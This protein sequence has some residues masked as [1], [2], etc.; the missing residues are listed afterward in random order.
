MYEF[1]LQKKKRRETEKKM[2]ILTCV[3]VRTLD[4]H[5]SIPPISRVKL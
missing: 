5:V 4:K 1:F 2:V 3:L